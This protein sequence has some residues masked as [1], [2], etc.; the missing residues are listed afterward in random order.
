M[1]V[2]K[3]TGMKQSEWV[4]HMPP[5]AGPVCWGPSGVDVLGKYTLGSETDCMLNEVRRQVIEDVC[6]MGPC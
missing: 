1:L 6:V 2:M 3:M 4:K 5:G